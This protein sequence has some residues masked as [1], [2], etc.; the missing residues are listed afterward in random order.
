MHSYRKPG[1]YVAI[2]NKTNFDGHYTKVFEYPQ[3]FIDGWHF[4]SEI[5]DAAWYFL[6]RIDFIACIEA[7]YPIES[8]QPVVDWTHTHNRKSVVC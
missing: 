3:S 6:N 4:E 7:V 8:F 1:T 5:P 2:C